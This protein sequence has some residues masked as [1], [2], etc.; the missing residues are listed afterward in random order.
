LGAWAA[1][2]N[3]GGGLFHGAQPAKPNDDAPQ[4]YDVSHLEQVDLYK[5]TGVTEGRDLSVTANTYIA[6]HYFRVQTS[7]YLTGD[8]REVFFLEPKENS[9][10]LKLMQSVSP[11]DLLVISTELEHNRLLAR[12]I[13]RYTLHDGEERPNVFL[14]VEAKASLVGSDTSMAVKL[15]KYGRFVGVRLPP[16]KAGAAPTAPESVL[17]EAVSHLVPGQMV[18]VETTGG[19][20]V[21]VVRKIAVLPPAQNGTLLKLTTLELDG[22]KVPGAVVMVGGEERTILV[23]GKKVGK[24][25][26]AGDDKAQAAMNRC[27]VGGG[28]TFRA[29][30]EGDKWWLRE[31][32]N[33]KPS[34]FGQ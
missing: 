23:P 2:D 9:T 25:H 22:A 20:G 34:V 18:E 33:A 27:K 8:H 13:G 4:A 28:V 31:M 24:D 19:E 10:L 12:N 5:I 15:Y 14:F 6:G 30:K 11:D 29:Y 17:A 21:P 3:G 1:D 16:V 26:W 32:V 7:N